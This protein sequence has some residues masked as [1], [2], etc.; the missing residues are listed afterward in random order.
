M[1]S[2]NNLKE[3]TIHGVF[4]NISGTFVR[5]SIGFVVG[6][7]LA[8]LLFPKEFGLIGLVTVF[9]SV[10]SSI[11]D[12]GFSRALIQKKDV[13]Q[14]DFDTVFWFN[15]VASL[16]M[17]GVIFLSA[18]LIANFFSELQL[19]P[20][21]RVLA[22]TLI[23]NSFGIVQRTILAKN[24]DFKTLTRMQLSAS[25]FPGMIA[26]FL[27]LKGFGVW[28]LVSQSILSSLILSVLSWQKCKWFPKFQFS[29][30][31]FHGLFAFGSKMLASVLLN[32]IYQN[33]YYVIIG[34]Y[35][36][37]TTLGFYTRADQFAN[38]V[39]Q[40]ISATVDAV[41]FPALSS[42]QEQPE[43]LK[44]GYRKAIRST[45]FVT[46]P[47]LFGLIVVAKPLVLF[48]IGE[49]WLPSV[50]Y[51]QL[52]CLAGMLHPLHTLNLGMLMVRGRSDL[53]LRL[54]VLKKVMIIP[55]VIISI[56]WG[57]T[58][59][60]YG[61]VTQSV[62]AYFLN[63]YYSGILV[64][65]P[66]KNQLRDI[67]PDLFVAA[68]T[69]LIVYVVGLALPDV[70]AVKLVLQTLLMAGLYYLMSR[71]WNSEAVD[72]FTEVVGLCRKGYNYSPGS[73]AV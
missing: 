64:G 37:A 1:S 44:R 54:E 23:T 63:G 59:L 47:L 60:I 4:W 55:I 7:V 21:L 32:T 72:D 53:F 18:G 8:R 48:A 65:Y 38:M 73:L 35:F 14:I 43:R 46:F 70:A 25:L 27:A 6:I 39:P 11:I 34:R 15:V 2:S 41:T 45:M 68:F 10:S 50:R 24:I 67:V 3:R 62:L 61:L 31:A 19:I 66:I 5:Q 16:L 71:L 36:S 9:I 52:L 22:L 40:S 57:V 42:I 13:T 30:R 58:G 33:A 12:S 69:G 29:F 26:V 51:L 20:I 49:K 17:Y 28:S 56:P